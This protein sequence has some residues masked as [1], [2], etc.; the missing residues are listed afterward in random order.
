MLF[1]VFLRFLSDFQPRNS[2]LEH[3]KAMGSGPGAPKTVPW[4]LQAHPATELGPAGAPGTG[5]VRSR[6]VLGRLGGSSG[7]GDASL[8]EP[9]WGPFW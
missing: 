4:E 6:G 8:W 9:F 1:L 5:L 2:P 7:V 3:Q